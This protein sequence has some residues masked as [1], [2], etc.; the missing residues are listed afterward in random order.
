[1]VLRHR[2]DDALFKPGREGFDR[3]APHCGLSVD[4]ENMRGTPWSISFG[5]PRDRAV[6]QQLDPLDGSVDAAVVADGEPGEAF[7]FFIPRGYLFPSLLLES[8]KFLVKVSDGLCILVLLL[9]MDSVALADG[10]YKLLREVAE[11]DWVVE[12]ESLDDV[13]GRGWGDR[14]D[15]RGRHG[16]SG[17]GTG[18]S[19]ERH[20]DV[21]VWG[22]EWERVG[23]VVAR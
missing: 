9:V 23:G 1:M 11:P 14:V 2:S 6:V 20:R 13:S 18:R 19:V 3:L 4:V 5:E 21:D 16:D 8:F 12:V 7:V 15:V 10:L 22:T 17:G